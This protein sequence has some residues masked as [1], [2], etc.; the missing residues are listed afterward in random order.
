M[1]TTSLRQ[2]T[3]HNNLHA[4]LFNATSAEYM[5]MTMQM[6]QLARRVVTERL[7]QRI[8]RKPVVILDLDETI[9]N[10]AAYQ[11]WLIRTG[12]NYADSTWNEWCDAYEAEA[13]P[14][15][16]EFV[17]FVQHA[18]VTPIFIPVAITKLGQAHVKF[19][20]AGPHL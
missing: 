8:F 14:G 10:N 13:V 20:Q 17:L 18:G 7:A 15:A 4:L 1:N 3:A 12:S 11:A 5:V 19:V 16:I 2:M 6:Y 9:L